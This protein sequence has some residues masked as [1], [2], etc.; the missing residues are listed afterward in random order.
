MP[1]ENTSR[2]GSERPEQYYYC[3]Y[4]TTTTTTITSYRPGA[5]ESGHL[6]GRQRH[7]QL[8][9]GPGLPLIS[10]CRTWFDKALL[11]TNPSLFFGGVVSFSGRL[12]HLEA[13]V[14]PFEAYKDG[15][16]AATV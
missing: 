5:E 12:R 2:R 10:T 14:L 7:K 3:T 16:P 4:T 6:Q 13:E 1:I 9:A 8:A 15:I 11:F